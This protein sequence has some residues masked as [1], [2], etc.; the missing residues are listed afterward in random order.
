MK[1]KNLLLSLIFLTLPALAAAPFN[2][3]QEV[4]IKQLIR[5]TLVQ[6]P[7]I[8]AEAVAELDKE[9]A[10]QQQS[11]VAQVVEKNHEALFNDAGSPRIGAARPALTLV[12]FT[13]YNCVFCKK[14]E[15][16]IEKMLKANPQVAVVLKPLPYRAE[17]SLTSARLALTVWE[18]QP[19]NFLKLHER[20]MSK[21]GNHDEASI[22]AAMEK[23]GIKLDEPSKTSLDTVNL[24]LTLAQQLGVQGTP[25]T[26]VG[27]QLISGAVPY[28][29]LEAAVKNV[30]EAKP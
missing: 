22:K 20:L 5:E 18:Q 2:S 26:L 21:K 8:L 3:E 10:R 13:D 15:A 17:S 14:F 23:N 24:N 25:A 28:A 4:L 12:Y 30:L 29:Q 19:G 16:D 6:N 9:A 7:S 27:N 11:V 1:K